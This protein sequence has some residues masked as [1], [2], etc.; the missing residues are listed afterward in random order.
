MFLN[1]T[2]VC[3]IQQFVPTLPSKATSRALPPMQSRSNLCVLHGVVA[4]MVARVEWRWWCGLV[5]VQVVHIC[6]RGLCH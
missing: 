1:N 4:V 5:L 2:T 3:T 6:A